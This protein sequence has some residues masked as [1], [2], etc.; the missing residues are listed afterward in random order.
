MGRRDE[1]SVPSQP[2]WVSGGSSRNKTRPE[3][4][5]LTPTL[6]LL[7][8][9]GPE[10]LESIQPLYLLLWASGVYRPVP[11]EISVTVRE[12]PAFFVETDLPTH[13]RHGV[14]LGSLEVPRVKKCTQEGPEVGV[15]WLVHKWS[16]QPTLSPSRSTRRSPP[17]PHP[18]TSSSGPPLSPVLPVG[19]FVFATVVRCL[20]LGFSIPLR[21]QG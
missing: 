10:F 11:T 9:Q 13:H 7:L 8:R 15:S 12:L 21:H 17:R 5:P 2:R 6:L 16:V 14:R 3:A 19:S 18:S 1:R 4:L 20:R